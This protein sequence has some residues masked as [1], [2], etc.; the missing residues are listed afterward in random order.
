LR[1]KIKLIALLAVF[2]LVFAACGGDDDDD[3][4]TTAGGDDVTTTLAGGDDTTTT[5][6]VEET[7]TTAMAETTTTGDG[8]AAGEPI[9]ACQVTDTG[10]IDD[11]SFNQTAFKGITDAIEA[12]LATP[13]S[14]YLE[15]QAAT[16]FSRTS[17]RPSSGVVTW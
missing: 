13:D 6:M 5:A 12:G 4:T 14:D 15:S 16:D 8:T 7:T 11:K 17:T 9:L 1:S 10:G 3:T 2:A